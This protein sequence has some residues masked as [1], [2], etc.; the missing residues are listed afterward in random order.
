MELLSTAMAPEFGETQAT[1][2]FGFSSSTHDQ[3]REDATVLPTME[4]LDLLVAELDRI[5][6]TLAQLG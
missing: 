3:D 6:A 4:D 5:D 1:A 2:Q